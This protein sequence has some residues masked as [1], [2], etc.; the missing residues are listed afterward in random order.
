MSN[1]KENLMEKRIGTISIFVGKNADKTSVNDLL[2]SFSPLILARQGLPFREKELSIIC[3]IVEGESDVI[4]QL[5]GKLGRLSD[6]EVKTV[7]LK[8]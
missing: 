7:L 6:V 5:S 2:S 3:L 8:Q 1:P 4:N